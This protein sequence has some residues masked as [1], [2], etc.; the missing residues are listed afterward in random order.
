MLRIF[1][2]S[3]FALAIVIGLGY[4][5]QRD[6]GYILLSY[7]NV[8][9]E[10]SLWA[11]LLATLLL[12]TAL[13]WL[14]RIFL[15]LRY[16]GKSFRH[17]REGRQAKRNEVRVTQGLIQYMEG[18][19]KSSAR[20]FA[21]GAEKSPAPLLSY[22]MAARASNAI[23]EHEQCEQFLQKA[24]ASTP[25]A[26]IAIGLTQAELQMNN[27]QYE[28]CLANLNRI[29]ETQPENSLAVRMLTTVYEQLGDW[30][31]L[32]ELLPL[33]RKKKLL[34]VEKIEALES[35]TLNALFSQ[36]ESAADLSTQWGGVSKKLKQDAGTVQAYAEAL[37][38]HGAQVEAEAVLR[39]SLKKT[40]Q[41][42]L[43]NLFG[44]T[45][46]ANPAK[47]LSTA[48]SWLKDHPNDP[49]LLLTLGRLSLQNEKWEKAKEYFSSSLSLK[50]N[51]EGYGELG[52]LLAH[53]GDNEQSSE[54]YQQGLL[55]STEGL[56]ALPQPE[57][58]T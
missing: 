18:D 24:E 55:L 27:G 11:G 4:L 56:P 40:W 6:A 32:K 30:A 26:H 47:Q 34:S 3:I 43:L 31:G 7:D 49:D 45:K 8:S 28:N 22:L 51:A 10:T 38:T 44:K 25:N 1:F 36:S 5:I 12:V 20:T 21:N 57:A 29:R 42:E 17:W 9:I 23:G 2:V 33:V 37:L 14:I 16:S 35:K 13:Y 48:E 41:P 58:S 15:K 52:R 50:P 53:L 54:Q 19:W 39:T 46:G